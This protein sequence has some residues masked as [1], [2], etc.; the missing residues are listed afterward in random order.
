VQTG[1]KV[2]SQP[3][4]QVFV[5]NYTILQYIVVHDAHD[6]NENQVNFLMQLT[7]CLLEFSRWS[8]YQNIEDCTEVQQPCGNNSRAWRPFHISSFCFLFRVYTYLEGL[9]LV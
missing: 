4:V 5:Q 9:L 6:V 8:Y 3:N 2:N 1:Q 7:T